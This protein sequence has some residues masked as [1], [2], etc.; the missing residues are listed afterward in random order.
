[1]KNEHIASNIESKLNNGQTLKT[2]YNYLL[3]NLDSDGCA[4]LKYPQHG[5]ELVYISNP[6]FQ[7]GATNGGGSGMYAKL[8]RVGMIKTIKIF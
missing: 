3:K 2:V 7:Q 5:F 1:M 8:Q 6:N 4:S